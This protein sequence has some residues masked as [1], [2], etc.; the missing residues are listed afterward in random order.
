MKVVTITL[1]AMFMPP[2]TFVMAQSGAGGAGNAAAAASIGSM[3]DGTVGNDTGSAR[4]PAMPSAGASDQGAPTAAAPNSQ[5]TGTE[6]GTVQ[7]GTSR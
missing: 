3:N 5:G 7:K 2:A 1:A 6:P 4:M